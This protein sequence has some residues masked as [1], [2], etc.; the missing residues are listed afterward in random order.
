MIYL[1][2]LVVRQKGK[3]VGYHSQEMHRVIL[4]SI[5]YRFQCILHLKKSNTMI[6]VGSEK[7]K[8]TAAVL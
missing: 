1:S 8:T 2:T 5:R 4:L 6:H 7:N 3:G